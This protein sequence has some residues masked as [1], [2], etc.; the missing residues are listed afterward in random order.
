MRRFL[1]LAL[2]LLSLLPCITGCSVRNAPKEKSYFSY[3]DTFT[4]ISSYAG[5]GEARFL[6]NCAA[7]EDLLSRYHK[8]FDIYNPYDGANNL[9]TVNEM[10]GVAPVKVD[11]ELID[12]LLYAK[13]IYELTEGETNIALGAVLSL[14]HDCRAA[15]LDGGNATL[16][17]PAALKEA[18]AHTS[19][20]LLVIDEA[21]GTVYLTDA[22][23]SLDVGAIG[24]GYAVERAAAL[25]EERGAAGYVLNVGGNL[26]A[27]GTKPDGEG[28]VTGITDP[29]GGDALLA[30]LTLSDAALV[31]SGNYE[32]YYTVDGE[33]Y[34][35][36]I[37]KDTL[38][39]AR[40]FSSVTVLTADSGL[41]DALSTALFCMT[42][43]EGAALLSSLPEADALWVTETGEI[44]MTDGMKQ[45]L[46]P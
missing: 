44:K 35:H 25:L 9:Y 12:F 14:W 34:H 28:W 37:D 10:A 45:K 30:T 17:D 16:P 4:T 23:A 24:K 11:G 26:H 31:T 32:R 42:Y 36:I 38:Y 15:A 40:G 39:P 2:V 20:D 46:L 27:I 33:R 13:E 43:E 3:F 29:K 18:E 5:D 41:A 8:L 1:S 21:A 19:I 6:E 7:V 22:D